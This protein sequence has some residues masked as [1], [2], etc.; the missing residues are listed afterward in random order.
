MKLLKTGND[1]PEPAKDVSRAPQMQLSDSNFPMGN[2]GRQNS[3]G[4]RC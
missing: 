1:K 3:P 4:A 2:N